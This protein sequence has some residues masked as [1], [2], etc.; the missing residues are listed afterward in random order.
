MNVKKPKH[1]PSIPTWLKI[2]RG[3]LKWRN[4]RKQRRREFNEELYAV[5]YFYNTL[6]RNPRLLLIHS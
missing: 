4:G 6:R 1:G 5:N 2:R 3:R